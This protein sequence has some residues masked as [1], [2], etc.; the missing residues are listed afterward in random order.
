MKWVVT[1]A[2][3]GR[4]ETDYY[5]VDAR[6]ENSALRKVAEKVYPDM[7]DP[8]DPE[9]LTFEEFFQDCISTDCGYIL[10]IYKAT[11]VK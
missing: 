1:G 5:V 8:K 3:S 4:E 11:E 10:E 6:T 7:H 9:D 2:V